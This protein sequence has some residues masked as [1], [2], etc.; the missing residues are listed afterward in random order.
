ML[1]GEAA[2]EAYQAG[3]NEPTTLWHETN[4]AQI[5]DLL[6][7]KHLLQ[8]AKHFPQYKPLQ[9]KSTLIPV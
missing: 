5:L 4:I 3:K 7:S 1:W 8:S 9:V 2:I 6:D